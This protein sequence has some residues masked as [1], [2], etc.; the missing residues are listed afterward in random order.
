MSGRWAGLE[1]RMR[2]LIHL[3]AGF[4]LAACASAVPAATAVDADSKRPVLYDATPTGGRVSNANGEYAAEAAR[5]AADYC[6]KGGLDMRVTG[7]TAERM[8][9]IFTCVPDQPG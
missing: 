9:L 8:S 4:S 5:M 1:T 2:S 6:W 7:I 3:L